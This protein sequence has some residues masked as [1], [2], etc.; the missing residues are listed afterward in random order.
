MMA[1]TT[2]TPPG[3]WPGRVLEGPAA[4]RGA[5]LAR[6]ETW[7][8]RFSSEELAELERALAGVRGLPRPVLDVTRENFVLPT[9]GPT[10]SVEVGR[11]GGVH[12]PASE[13]KAPL[14]A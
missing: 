6:G 5:A 9:L 11:R 2:S 10:G 8:H 7:L 3:T 4:W 1:S 13:L 14:E 12:V